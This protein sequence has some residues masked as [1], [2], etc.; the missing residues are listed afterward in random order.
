VGDSDLD[1]CQAL[2]NR[3]VDDPLL[4]LSLLVFINEFVFFANVCSMED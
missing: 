3:T 4:F 2:E 1:W